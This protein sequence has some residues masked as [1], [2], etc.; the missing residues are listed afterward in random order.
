MH[1]PNCGNTIEVGNQC[2]HCKIDAVLFKGTERMS[3]R[4]YN[5]GLERLHAMDFTRGISALTR[6]IAINKHNI[7]A[8][9]LLGLALFEVGHIGEAL[10]HWVIS[11]SQLRENN[12]AVTYLEK[13]NKNSRNFERLNEAVELYNR[14][15]DYLR[16]GSDDLAIIQ[17]K[18][19]QEYNPRFLD[20][21]NLLTLCHLQQRNRSQAIATMERVFS[22]DAHNPLA[23]RN[24]AII[25]PG[26]K[27][28]EGRKRG[29]FNNTPPAEPP[30]VN[31]AG[32]FKTI[33]IKEKKT[34][35]FHI[36]GIL[37]FIIGAAC[38]LAF[39]FFLFIPGIERAHEIALRE[40]RRDMDNATIEHEQAMEA[41]EGT[42]ARLQN[43]I[44]EAEAEV[45]LWQ[46]MHDQSDRIIRVLHAERHYNA[47][48]ITDLREAVDRIKIISL[49]GLPI[50]IAAIAIDILASAQPQLAA[51]YT[52][53]GID[54]FN[55]GDY[56]RA[57]VQLKDAQR[58]IAFD[59]PQLPHMLYF[60]GT[61]HYRAPARQDEAI[62]TLQMLVSLEGYAD[63]PF[64]PWNGRRTRVA[65]ML[66]N[67]GITVE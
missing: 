67:M 35:H 10:K 26:A 6:S 60:L 47:G 19:S 62:E 8:R 1:C 17:L 4:L 48:E 5:E 14:A 30:K 52:L 9:N 7:M 34:S 58:F 45:A 59:N 27:R 66:E 46:A 40:A 41:R 3:N 64:N 51:F 25:N 21:L 61:L 53:G 37:S 57:L 15:L 50:D 24:F 39:G 65:A 12:P 16:Q 63:L 2:P 38:M 33:A 18:K 44:D 42:E 49:E 23:L 13:I 36:V 54:S 56:D 20:T 29:L 11:Q 22:I 28:G 31:E 55:A 32:P 43:Q